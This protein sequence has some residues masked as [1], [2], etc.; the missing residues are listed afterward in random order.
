MGRRPRRIRRAAPLVGRTTRPVLGIG[1]GRRGRRG[2]TRRHGP[3]AGRGDV[4]RAVLPRRDVELRRQPVAAL[5][6]RTRPRLRPGRRPALHHVVGRAP[7]VGL[8]GAA[9]AARRGRGARRP[10]R[11]VVAER[12]RGVRAAARGREPRRRVLVV[13][14][15]LRR[16]RRAR[17]VRPDRADR[18][19]RGRR[20][21][22]RRPDVRLSRAV[23][24]D[25]RRP[26]V[27]AVRRRARLRR[28]SR[29][30]AGDSGR[31]SR[32][33]TGSPATRPRRSSSRAL[34]FDHPLYVLYSSGTT[35]L[36][37]CIVH[38]AG[39]VLLKHLVEHRLHC[40]VEAGRPRLLLHDDRAG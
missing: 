11:G 9:G 5:R 14:A 39:G 4:A 35:G 3:R 23:A 18:A 32:G 26:A 33:T 19:R 31:A 21:P 13:L 40:D 22:L 17:P 10:G 38:R 1:V 27:G 29:R 15:R 20:V 2:R 6:R 12:A 30:P 36:P 24:R 34:P 8:A 25:P 37:K 16:R 7:R 28:R